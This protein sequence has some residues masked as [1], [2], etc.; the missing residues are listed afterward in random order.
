[1]AMSMIFRPRSG[2][3]WHRQNEIFNKNNYL[4]FFDV[5]APVPRVYAGRSIGITDSHPFPSR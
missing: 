3:C 2:W 5:V 4:R 1:M